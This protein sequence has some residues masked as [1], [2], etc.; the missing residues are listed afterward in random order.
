MGKRTTGTF[1]RRKHDKY[2]TPEAALL[3]LLPYLPQENFLFIEPCAG[4]GR[5]AGYIA[6]NSKGAC[7]EA[8]DVEPQAEW[9][10]PR[11]AFTLTDDDYWV[12]DMFITNPP[13][14]R[15]LLHPMIVHLSDILPTWL[16]F[17]ADWLFTKQAAPYLQRL[18]KVVAVG[19]VSWMENGVSGKDNAA[20][21]LFDRTNNAQTEFYGRAA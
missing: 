6:A 16:L 17:D 21:Y 19:R 7:V 20:W 5:F 11:D 4:D 14:T 3:P 13:W 15:K 9:V 18:K 2:M 10:T 12:A 8:F 1:P